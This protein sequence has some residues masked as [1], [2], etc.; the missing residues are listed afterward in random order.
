[1]HEF[2]ELDL[3]EI[4]MILLQKIWVILLCALIGGLAAYIYT[5]NF[6]TPLYR[7]SVSIYVNN[8]KNNMQSNQDDYISGGNLAT[9]QQLVKTYVNIIKSNTV[10]ERVAQEANLKY[11]AEAIR[12]MMTAE[13]VEETEI[14]NIQISHPDP[15]MAAAIANAIANVAPDEI[16]GFLDGSSTKIIDYAKVPQS[17]YTPSFRVNT[18]VGCCIGGL[19]AV[20]FA[21]VQ[22][23]MDVRIKCEEDLEQLF[24]LPILGAIPEF[25]NEHKGGKYGR[26]SH[27]GYYGHYARYEGEQGGEKSEDKKGGAGHENH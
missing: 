18:F 14:F 6:I 16:A 7:A 20:I 1:M 15:K 13:S 12:G 5:A 25:G 26:Y 22:A 4:A 21:I 17:R 23:I 19:L 8:G 2:T 24:T 3:K 11:S 27:Y 9:S 10:L